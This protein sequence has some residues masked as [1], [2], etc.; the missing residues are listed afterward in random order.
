VSNPSDPPERQ[1]PTDR[2]DPT[3]RWDPTDRWDPPDASTPPGQGRPDPVHGMGGAAPARSALTLRIV[4]S[5][6]GVVFCGAAAIVLVVIG[7]A[8]VVAAL[9]ALFALVALIDLVVVLRRKRAGEPG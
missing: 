7:R 6:F 4:L 1:H 9:L 3:E 2:Q 8:L 5:A